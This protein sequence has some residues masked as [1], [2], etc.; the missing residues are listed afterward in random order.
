MGRDI[1]SRIPS[2]TARHP[3]GVKKP[4]FALILAC[5]LALV[6]GLGFWAL[7]IVSQSSP[8]GA[9]HP[10][11]VLSASGA[12]RKIGPRS[13][14]AALLTFVPAGDANNIGTAIC[15]A[16]GHNRC[17]IPGGF[18]GQIVVGPARD[19]HY[20]VTVTVPVNIRRLLAGGEISTGAAP[21][22]SDLKTGNLAVSTNEAVYGVKMNPRNHLAVYRFW[23]ATNDTRVWALDWNALGAESQSSSLQ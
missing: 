11:P 3:R 13:A 8:K 14:Q 7:R 9:I 5:L 15:R 10:T 16:T 21:G 6:G 1:D 22:A 4:G 12:V 18:P 17:Q 19:G 23:L 2:E 20:I